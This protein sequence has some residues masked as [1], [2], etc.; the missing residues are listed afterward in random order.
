MESIEIDEV[1]GIDGSIETNEVDGVDKKATVHVETDR[2]TPLHVRAI[3][4][5]TARDAVR[6][7]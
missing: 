1:D 4:A 5:A 2:V 3:A 7:R 6:L